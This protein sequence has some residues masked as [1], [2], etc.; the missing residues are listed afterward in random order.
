MVTNIQERAAK[1]HWNVS[2]VLFPFWL[3]APWLRM[4]PPEAEPEMENVVLVVYWGFQEKSVKQVREAGWDRGETKY[5]LASAEVQFQPDL[6]GLWRRDA[7]QSCLIL[8]QWGWAFDPIPVSLWLWAAPRVDCHLWAFPVKMASVGQ[9]QLP[10]EGS[11]FELLAA[12]S[13]RCWWMGA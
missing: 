9:E 1:R 4:G 6:Q 12:P 8:R 13:H 7:P 3:P 5:T 10:R 2:N 11:S